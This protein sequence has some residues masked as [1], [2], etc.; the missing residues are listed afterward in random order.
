[1]D[2]L[3]NLTNNWRVWLY[4]SWY[5]VPLKEIYDIICNQIIKKG[6]I[7]GKSRS[8]ASSLAIIIQVMFTILKTM[9]SVLSSYFY[10]GTVKSNFEWTIVIR[11]FCLKQKVVSISNTKRKWYNS[12]LWL[13]RMNIIF[14]FKLKIFRLFFTLP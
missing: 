9:K 14:S 8:L 4:L 10:S 6:V 1:M 2:S 11:L 7:M 12:T 13:F 5:T 3:E